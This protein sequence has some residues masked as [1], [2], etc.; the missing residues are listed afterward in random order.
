MK[1][2]ICTST[3]SFRTLREGGF[4]YVDKTKEIF[5]LVRPETAQVFCARP[6]RFGKS[7]MI[8]TLEALFQGDRELFEGLY[9]TENEVPYNWEEYPVI[10]LNLT[11]CNASS[12]ECPKGV[13]PTS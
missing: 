3:Y 5:D 6:R 1:K 9:I 11:S 7:L 8:S 2:S 4:V 10:H 12:P 13:C